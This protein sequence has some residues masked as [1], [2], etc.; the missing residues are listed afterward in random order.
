MR[1]NSTIPSRGIFSVPPRDMFNIPE[2]S[3]KST[4]YKYSPTN[5]KVHLVESYS[6][7]FN[8]S[9]NPTTPT[10]ISD[11]KIRQYIWSQI[12]ND[13]QYP[14]DL[15]R[16]DGNKNHWHKAKEKWDASLSATKCDFILNSDYILIDKSHPYACNNYDLADGYRFKM[17]D[18]NISRSDIHQ[19]KYNLGHFRRRYMNLE[20]FTID[21]RGAFFITLLFMRLSCM[22]IHTAELHS[23]S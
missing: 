8:P 21:G 9:T 12:F 5:S 7:T 22:Q 11:S 6:P 20:G 14:K 23:A 18:L 19:W 10:K 16:Y 2:G 1:T 3:Y 15:K 13:K 17:L 4:A